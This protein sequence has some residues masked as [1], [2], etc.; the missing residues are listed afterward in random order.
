MRTQE[1][2]R[3]GCGVKPACKLVDVLRDG[4]A[5]AS[6]ATL[7]LG[8]QQRRVLGALLACRSE[9]AGGHR[10]RCADCEKEFFVPHRCGNRHCPQC[11]GREA[12]QW[13]LRQSASVLPAPYFHVVLTLPHG[14]NPLIRQNQAAL[15]RLLFSAASSTLLNFARQRFGGVPGITA[16]LHTW[17]QTLSEHYHLH[18]IVTAGAMSDCQRRW[19]NGSGRYLFAVK[20][21]SKVF[22]ARMR[23]GIRTLFSE[24]ALQFHGTLGEL[25]EPEAFERWLAAVVRRRWV[26]YSKRPFAGPEQVLRYLSRYTHRV[27]IGNGRLLKLDSERHTLRFRYK[28]YADHGRHKEME[29]DTREF[30]R[31]FSLHILPKGFQKI[32]HF[33]LLSNRNRKEKV[34]AAR[35]LLEKQEEKAAQPPLPASAAKPPRGTTLPQG[36]PAPV[37]PQP[38]CPCCG[39]ERLILLGEKPR[40]ILPVRLPFTD[41]S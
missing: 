39:S 16:V 20:A 38:R 8:A 5:Q 25:Q 28:D 19:S 7:P 1:S 40:R 14:L 33:G 18:C 41:S 36:A 30:V 27:A 37:A 6:A 24:G 32:R 3:G 2:R 23:D 35:T 4:L 12:A 26:V 15:Y 21:L 9:A 22:R 11:Q 10:F 17:S 34:A 29:L 13:L 31:R